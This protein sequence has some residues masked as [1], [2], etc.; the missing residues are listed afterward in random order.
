M[1]A[2]T[3]TTPTVPNATV[4][5]VIDTI[6]SVVAL[7]LA[8]RLTGLSTTVEGQLHTFDQ[9]ADAKVDAI[10]A[11]LDK[12]ETSNPYVVEV[13]TALTSIAKAVGFA[14][15][16]EDQIFTHLKLAIDE[17]F[18]TIQTSGGTVTPAPAAA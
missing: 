10:R 7:T 13:M 1:S 17:L 2:T 4:V 15:P 11:A 12:G 5:T 8:G 16:P 3:T 14:L 6:T 18:D 9:D